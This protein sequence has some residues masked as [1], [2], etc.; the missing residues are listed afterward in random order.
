V[1]ERV[2][3]YRAAIVKVE[4]RLT[5]KMAL[6]AGKYYCYGLHPHLTSRW[7]GDGGGC[8]TELTLSAI[9]PLKR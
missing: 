7:R 6:N 4:G 1:G 9:Q 5:Q 3:N 8:R 2:G